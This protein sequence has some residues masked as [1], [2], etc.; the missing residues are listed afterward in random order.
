MAR[1]SFSSSKGQD[2]WP[3]QVLIFASCCK[4]KKK[5]CLWMNLDYHRSSVAWLFF[6]LIMQL[7]LFFFIMS[8]QIAPIYTIFH[9]KRARKL[10][11]RGYPHLQVAVNF[12][13]KH[14]HVWI[15]TTTEEVLLGFLLCPHYAASSL[16]SF[17]M[18]PIFT[19]FIPKGQENWFPEAHIFSS[20]CK[21]P[22]Y[23]NLDYH[24]MSVARLSFLSSLCSFRV[25]SLE[26][27]SIAEFSGE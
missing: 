1:L 12:K 9:T 11:A 27:L 13:R 10:A 15:W 4:L 8:F 26:Q 24:R 20:C 3:P 2:N 7:H 25:T 17:Q 16:M 19:T 23:M 22:S 6:V 18:A 21:T 5:K 14:P